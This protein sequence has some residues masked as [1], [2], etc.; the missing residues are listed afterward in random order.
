M[1]AKI[2]RNHRLLMEHIGGDDAEAIGRHY[3]LTGSAVRAI[4]VRHGR[5]VI[6]DLELRLLANRTTDDVELFLIP[7]HGGADFDL[8]IEWFRWCIA[9]LAERGVR[10][11][12]HYRPAESGVA[13]AGSVR[14]GASLIALQQTYGSSL[15]HLF[16][17]VGAGPP[18]WLRTRRRSTRRLLVA[19]RACGAARACRALL[20]RA[21]PHSRRPAARAPGELTSPQSSPQ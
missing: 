5:R 2:E 20:R 3:G 10:T 7:E 16:R 19:R 14:D 4:V 11:R 8:A 18:S 6:D 9:Q 17:C 21:A 13:F 1:Q 15:A 12:V